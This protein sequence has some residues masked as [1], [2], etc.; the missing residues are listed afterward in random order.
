MQVQRTIAGTHR[1]MP[2]TPSQALAIALSIACAAAPALAQ[3]PATRPVPRP[4][5]TAAPKPEP[6]EVAHVV[7]K[8]DTLWDIAEAYL[9][10]PF[11]WPEVFRRNTAVVEIAHWIYPGETILIPS[12]EVRPDVLARISTRPAP[13]SDR[14][15]FSTL[16]MRVSDRVQSS[17]EVIGREGAGAVRRGEVEAAPFASQR[18]GP[19]GSGRL[20]AAYDRPGIDAPAG[21]HTFQLNDPVFIELPA[22]GG[23]R[24]GAE[25]LAYRRGPSINE[26]A[27]VMIPTG[28][29]RVESMQAGQPALARIVKQFDEIRL[30]QRIMA[31]EVFVM[32]RPGSPVTVA[33]GPIEKVV[34]VSGEPVL[35][36]LQSYVMLSSTAAAGVRVG[37][38]FTLVDDSIDERYPAPAVPAAVAQVVRVTPY[39]LTAIVLDHDQPTIRPGMTARL[40]AR[41]P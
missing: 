1:L 41:T 3:D 34:Y 25:F 30:D 31:L 40:T 23:A 15:V 8:G 7:K 9:K 20:A 32:S 35:P 24:I 6:N 18:G 11:R 33:M 26:V 12:D 14:T 27:Q 37:D 19:P 28:I 22:A 39:A 4:T 2:V 17:G 16:P 29:V 38:R 21:D 5:L 13:V 10:D 36:S